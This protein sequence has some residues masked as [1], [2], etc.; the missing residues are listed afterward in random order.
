MKV[1]KISQISGE[2]VIIENETYL[3]MKGYWFKFTDNKPTL[4][5]ELHYSSLF[6]AY[7]EFKNSKLKRPFSY[8]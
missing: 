1:S 4:V 2:L 5:S 8:E 7:M 3:L 6:S